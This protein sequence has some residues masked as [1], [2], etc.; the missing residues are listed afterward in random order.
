MFFNCK[1]GGGELCTTKIQPW[2]TLLLPVRLESKSSEQG[3]VQYAKGIAPNCFHSVK[4]GWRLLHGHCV[5]RLTVLNE[6]M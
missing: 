1:K 2:I 5:F 3:R 6:G 4:Y